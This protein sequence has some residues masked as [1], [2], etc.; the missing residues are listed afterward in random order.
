MIS[1]PATMGWAPGGFVV[2]LDDAGT[3]ATWIWATRIGGPGDD[4]INAVA[5]NCNSIYYAGR[6]ERPPFRLP[7]GTWYTIGK[8]TDAGST[9]TLT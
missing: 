9:F 2:K 1:L 4:Y 6:I 5:L 8:L 7:T 3:S